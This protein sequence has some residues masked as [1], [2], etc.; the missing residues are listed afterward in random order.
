MTRTQSLLNIV[1]TAAIVLSPTLILSMKGG[2]G[3]CF[4]T[5]LVLS[6]VYLGRAEN[7]RAAARLWRTHRWFLGSLLGLPCIVLFQILVMG[8]G[9]FP[10]L[11]PLLRLA[12]SIP[13]F[14]LLASLPSRQLR[15]VQWG[16]VAGALATGAWA[17]Y[18]TLHPEV[19]FDPGRLG[20]SFTNPIPFG[21]TALLL[22]FLAIASIP[23][24]ESVVP[25]M[26]VAV[27]LVAL[28]GGIYASYLS[29][30]RGGW[31]AI[32]M[33]LWFAIAGKHW[34]ADRR[35]RVIFVAVLAGCVIVAASTHGISTRFAAI[36]SDVQ[37][38]QEGNS[39]TST[40]A[41]L[42]L[43]RASAQ[44]YA[45]HPVLGVGRGSLESALGELAKRGEV[46]K[47]VVNGR[48]HSEFF[49]VLAEMGTL[50]ILALLTLYGATFAAF[51]RARRSTDPDTVVAAYL[52]M[53]LVGS[54]ILFGLTIDVLTLV[55]NVAFFGLT[56]VTLLAWIEARAREIAASGR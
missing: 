6:L 39:S 20:N 17:V 51:W 9:K 12:L 22:A 26:E 47:F 34:L 21:D 15:L 46:P 53:S 32:P 11:D 49:S 37:E 29:G 45:A 42:D 14:F 4:F 10:A 38:M 27:K 48:A 44:I 36:G 25:P 35:A 2:A 1:A 5:V 3:Y 56:A 24:T 54:T 13:S 30:T 23:R 18:A 50:G 16:F 41:R 8:T 28:I 43:W 19:W 55:M 31:I 52:G 33:L 7:R 40:G